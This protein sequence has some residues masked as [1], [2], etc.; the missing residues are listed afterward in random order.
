MSEAKKIRNKWLTIRMTEAEYEELR[1]LCKKT[2]CRQLS[3]YGRNVL[4]NKPVYVRFR[5]ESLDAFLAEIIDLRREFKAVGFNF[6]QVVH[7]L[8]TLQ[9]IPEFR[10]WVLV[11]EKHKDLFFSKMKAIQDRINEA[12]ELWGKGLLAKAPKSAE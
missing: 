9:E 5:N 8:H 2:T 6:N 3:Q 4:L 7:K 1:R 10:A 12:Y 11:N